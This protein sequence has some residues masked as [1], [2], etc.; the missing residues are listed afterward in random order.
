VNLVELTRN[1]EA[2]GTLAADAETVVS[3]EVEARVARLAADMGDQ[4]AAGAPLVVLDSEKLRYRADG[5]R[6]A[7][8]QTRAQLGARGQEL[9]KAE[10]APEVVSAL[11]RRAEAEQG[12]MRARQLA[13]KK[14]LSAQE[15]ERAETQLQTAQAA[16]EAALAAARHLLAEV[17]ARE[18]A[19]KGA[20]RELEDAVI[21]APFAGVVAERLVS[22][23]Q[24]VRV[25][26]PV[27]RIVRLHPLRVTARIPERFAPDVRVGHAVT[28]RLD[29]YPERPVEG[30]VTRISPDVDQRSR[31]FSI[32]A[33]VPN[34]DGA[35]KPGTFARVNVVTDRVEKTIAVPVSAVQT[36][37]GRSVLF[38]V[39]DGKLNAA[40][41]KLGDR[42]G[43]RV[44]ITEGVE[45]GATIVADNVEGLA[46]GQAVAP[47][48]PAADAGKDASR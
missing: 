14:L 37:Y 18:A 13:A 36:R 2:V 12:V 45:A 25:Q 5:Q 34:V 3:A 9:P 48:K 16:H 23:G 20:S 19:L 39:R 30:R 6:A 15:L 21:R 24:F 29:A 11:A 1:V 46:D 31:A 7:L 22:P 26:T 32:E 40:E 35:L 27:M 28:V 43:P 47:R 44:E 8:N 10:E 38:I 33:Q 41:V 4:V 17:N 42:L